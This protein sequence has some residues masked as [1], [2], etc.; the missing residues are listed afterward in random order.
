V[1]CAQRE[2]ELRRQPCK[3]IEERSGIDA[4]GES[5]REANPAREPRRERVA[6]RRDDFS[7]PALP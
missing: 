6:N 3:D 7:R 1:D 2:P 5:D 4:A